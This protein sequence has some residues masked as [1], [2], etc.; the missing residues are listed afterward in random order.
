[1][2]SSVQRRGDVFGCVRTRVSLRRHVFGRLRVPLASAD[3]CAGPTRGKTASTARF[4]RAGEGESRHD[5][6]QRAA[7]LQQVHGRLIEHRARRQLGV[8][9]RA[10]PFRCESR[11]GVPI[12]STGAPSAAATPS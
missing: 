2:S 12:C 7:D 6:R 1:M 9:R 10:L 3:A 8:H 11:Q 5:H 4:E